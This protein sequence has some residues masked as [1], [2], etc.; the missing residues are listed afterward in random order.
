VG[1]SGLLVTAGARVR[2]G[3]AADR[4]TLTPLQWRYLAHAYQ[5][6]AEKERARA[7]E[8]TGDDARGFEISA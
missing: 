2:F 3:H 1:R 7:A 4:P 8:L 5:V 6:V